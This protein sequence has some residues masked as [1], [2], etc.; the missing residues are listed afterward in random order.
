MTHLGTHDQLFP[1]LYISQLRILKESLAHILHRNPRFL[2]SLTRQE[3]LEFYA[4]K[5][6]INILFP[7]LQSF[8]TGVSV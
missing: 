3:F 1:T 8:S 7:V 4:F 6:T 2:D 5:D